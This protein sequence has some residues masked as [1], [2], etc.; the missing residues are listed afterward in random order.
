M[1]HERSWSLLERTAKT[2]AHAYL[3]AGNDRVGKRAIADRYAALLLQVDP[4][5][6]P[7]HPDFLTVDREEGARD[8]TVTQ[9]RALAERMQMTSARGGF[10]VALVPQADRLNEQAC[11]ALLK[12]VEE[13]SP[14]SVYLFLTERA[15]RLPATLRSR[16]VPF[17]FDLPP[18][19]RAVTDDRAMRLLA[20]LLKEPL[21]K[22][23]AELEAIAKMFEA[24]DDTETVWRDFL[25]ELMHGL[26]TLYLS[27]PMFAKRIG[28]GLCLA[29]KLSGTSLSPR[30]GLE[31][32][33]VQPYLRGERS[34][35]SFLKTS[36][37]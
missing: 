8:V 9:V 20:V 33:A 36:F 3:F 24:D 30:L 2:P 21:G 35:P 18:G 22:Q 11:N 16:L 13:P 37:V 28:Q 7:A 26:D 12:I 34:Y 23:V 15:E 29:W 32:A 31:W 5:Q 14:K 17:Q 6:L 10:Q 1:A 19:E 27:D 4:S 25:T